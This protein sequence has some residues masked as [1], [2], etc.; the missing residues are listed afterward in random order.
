MKTILVCGGAGFIGSNLCSYLLNKGEKVICVDNFSTGNMDNVK[1]FDSP[2]FSIIKHDITEPL[3]IDESID[4][5]Y[6]LASIASPPHYLNRP[7]DTLKTNVIG[8]LNLLELAFENDAKILQT[9]TSEVYGDPLEHPQKESYRGNVN[10]IGVR[11]CYDEGK[12]AAETLFFD[13]NRI[14]STK[15][16]VV[17]IFNTYGPNMDPYDGRVVSNFIIQSLKGEDITVTAVRE[18]D[19]LELTMAVDTAGR[20]GVHLIPLDV[21]S[22]KYTA[23][24]AIPA[25]FRK[26]GS[27]IG[28]Y[29]KDLK[30]VATPSTEAYK[31]VGS[32]ITL[33]QVFP[34]TW[35]WHSFLSILALLSIMLGVINLLPIPALDGGHIVFTLYEIITGRKPSEG[36][37]YAAQMIGLLLVLALMVLALGN[38][39]IRLIR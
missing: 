26:T 17:R 16:K 4:E 35:D 20:L 30:L 12:R 14:Y 5:I 24:T 25:G 19:T 21:Q 11:A 37:L 38:D 3:E 28:G 6:N 33:G 1:D 10:P 39:I 36:F 29:L 34:K 31:S 13:F 22:R 2:S 8:A 23:L 32:F 18:T 15:I 7:I 9:S 27:T